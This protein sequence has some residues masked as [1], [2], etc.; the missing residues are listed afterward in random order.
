MS[1]D[2]RGTFVTFGD[3]LTRD[4]SSPTVSITRRS[5]QSS[6]VTP[7]GARVTTMICV[8]VRATPVGSPVRAIASPTRAPSGE[9]RTTWDGP[10]AATTNP[11]SAAAA[12]P[13]AR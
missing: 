10:A 7:S 4:G 11:P 2:S 9:K 12:T 1:P 6:T 8:G 3:G 5:F 13:R